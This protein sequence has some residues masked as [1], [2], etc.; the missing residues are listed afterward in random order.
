MAALL[1]V[2]TALLVYRQWYHQPLE[3]ANPVT[4]EELQ[5]APDGTDSD[6]DGLTDV[7]EH[8]LKTDPNKV[9]SDGNGI[10][11]G[12]EDIDANGVPN[13]E[14]PWIAHFSATPS[15]ESDKPSLAEVQ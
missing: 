3:P 5:G 4:T 6:D 10:A 1:V 13:R 8:L 12:D 7:V 15:P 2:G 14:E 11:D 9:D